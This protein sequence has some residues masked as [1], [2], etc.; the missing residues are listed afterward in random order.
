MS[1][2]T[3]YSNICGVQ[4]ILFVQSVVYANYSG[5]ISD[6]DASHNVPNRLI[7]GY[8]YIHVHVHSLHCIVSICFI[9]TCTS[10]YFTW[11]EKE[12]GIEENKMCTNIVDRV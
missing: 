3:L 2:F 1:Y 7:L 10:Q 11:Q 9:M 12:I 5:M 6:N 4:Q 8:M